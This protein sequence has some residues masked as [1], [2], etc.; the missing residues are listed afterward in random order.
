MPSPPRGF[1]RRAGPA[2][3]AAI[4]AVHVAAWAETYPG[5]MP[6]PVIDARTVEKRV[7]RWRGILAA[8]PPAETVHVAEVDGRVVGFS[9][10]GRPRSVGGFAEAE[11]NGLYLLAA[12][13]GRGLGR[14]LIAAARAAARDIGAGSLGLWVLT[15]NVRA[16]GFYAAIG[17]VA[18]AERSEVLDGYGIAEIG[19]R[20]EV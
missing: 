7:E 2:D 8:E 6:Q 4:A 11:L 14:G 18:V 9:A 1:I 10:T 16:R 20:L 19:Y 12:C 13:H 5:I 17:A 3:V 15:E